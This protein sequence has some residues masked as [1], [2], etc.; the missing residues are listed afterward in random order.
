M[1]AQ[2]YG[3][4]GTVRAQGSLGNTKM[5]L[6]AYYWRWSRHSDETQE[7]LY[8]NWIP[9]KILRSRHQRSGSETGYGLGMPTQ[10][11]GWRPCVFIVYYPLII[12]LF[13]HY[14]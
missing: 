2:V 8:S 1:R 14:C 13:L 12:R 11:F 4:H 9:W 10:P 5:G 7:Y 3:D 6:E